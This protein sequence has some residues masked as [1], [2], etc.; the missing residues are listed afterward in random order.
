MGVL[1]QA[2][3]KLKARIMSVLSSHGTLVR[4]LAELET[5][6]RQAY[7]GRKLGFASVMQNSAC[8]GLGF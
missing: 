3:T 1:V 2:S 7:P 8:D 5:F 4:G 6:E